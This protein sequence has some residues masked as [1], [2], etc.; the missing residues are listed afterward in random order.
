MLPTPPNAAADPTKRDPKVLAMDL[1]SNQT[2]YC[3]QS[4]DVQWDKT[5][6]EGADYEGTVKLECSCSYHRAHLAQLPTPQT[7]YDMLPNGI[8]TFV[9][10]HPTGFSENNA[11]VKATLTMNVSGASHSLSRTVNIQ[12]DMMGAPA[13]TADAGGA[14]AAIAKA[15]DTGGAGAT[16]EAAHTA[17]SSTSDPISLD[18]AVSNPIRL[19][20]RKDVILL[21]Q[22]RA[23]VGDTVSV[24]IFQAG[25]TSDT[26]VAELLA[27]VRPGPTNRLKKWFVRLPGALLA[28][29]C[30]SPRITLRL[31]LWKAGRVVFNKTFLTLVLCDPS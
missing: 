25:S 21:G 19:V 3:S 22:F 5:E 29:K 30:D 1:S 28:Q 17:G 8:T 18:P 15:A 26:V 20:P 2:I 31:N 23:H 13:T 14:G 6:G 4:I 9:L 10:E 7:A 16:H 24:T 12:C 11:E 27:Q